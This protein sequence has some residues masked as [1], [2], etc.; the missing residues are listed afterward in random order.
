MTRKS[1][2]ETSVNYPSNLRNIPQKSRPHLCRG[3]CLRAGRFPIPSFTKRLPSTCQQRYAYHRFKSSVLNGLW[4]VLAE[5]ICKLKILEVFRLHTAGAE[6]I[7][8]IIC[9][10]YGFIWR[11]A[12][13]QWLRCCA[14]NGKV[15]DSIPAGVSAFY[16]DIKSFR[17]HYGPG[18]DSAS[19]RNEYQEHFLGVKPADA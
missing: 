3:R 2:H 18:V 9:R 19:N 15:A 8:V 10:L 7:V 16:I 1:Y 17:S 12:V 5:A 6:H 13:A 11:T 14:T 4:T